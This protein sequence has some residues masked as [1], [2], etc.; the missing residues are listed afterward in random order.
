MI[1]IPSRWKTPGFIIPR[2]PTPSWA[3]SW[4][5]VGQIIG[6]QHTQNIRPNWNFAFDY[7]LI[8]SVGAFQNA[9]TNHSAYR[10]SSWYQSK[11]KRYQNFFILMSNKIAA[12]DN[13]GIRSHT[14]LDSL[15][16]YRPGY[17][18]RTSRPWPCPARQQHFFVPH[19]HRHPIIPP[20]PTCSGSNMTWDKKIPS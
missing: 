3:I 20:P 5:Q 19:Q 8:N 4:Q 17:A 10:L 6:V 14:D 7:R 1:C 2:G 15:R 9:N 12:S 13:G 11:S 18:A 16:L